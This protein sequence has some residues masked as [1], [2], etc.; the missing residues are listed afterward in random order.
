[1]I[2]PQPVQAPAAVVRPV[3]IIQPPMPNPVVRPAAH[4]F[5]EPN[6]ADIMRLVDMGFT[7]ELVVNALKAAFNNMDRATEYLLTVFLSFS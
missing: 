7:R 2:P 1:M 5:G 3:P 6:E 4:G